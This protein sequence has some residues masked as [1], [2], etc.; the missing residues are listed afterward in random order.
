L[1]T[2]WEA[3]P[4]LTFYSQ[5]ATAADPT[6]ANIFNLRPTQPQLLTTSRTYE[7]CV[8]HLFW[9]NKAEWTLSLFDIE[10]R[11]VYV[12]ES[13][14][15]FNVAGKIASRGVELAGAINPFGGSLGGLKLWG[16]VSFLRTRFID[17]NFV[18][19]NGVVQSYS[20]NTPPNVPCFIANAGAS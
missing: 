8:K 17:F 3:I 14:Q 15:I 19:G 16:N 2:T 1:G 6:V 20:S 5:Y 4:G 10:R 18:D 11:N 7:T 9:N 13:D 12:P